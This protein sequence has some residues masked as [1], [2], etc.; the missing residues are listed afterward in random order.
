M[1]RAILTL[2][3]FALVATGFG[4]LSAQ[5]AEQDLTLT[6]CLVQKEAEGDEVA[7]RLEGATDEALSA[8][9][10]HIVAAEGISLG[11]HV[12]HTIEITGAPVAMEAAEA[13]A[14]LAPEPQ[15]DPQ[16]EPP[17]QPELP[18]PPPPAEAQPEAPPAPEEKPEE[19][20]PEA[21]KGADDEEALQI[22]VTELRH[23]AAS[24][25]NMR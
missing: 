15:A 10:I 23:V 16:P 4:P 13:A 3:T 22:R 24:C 21:A 25:G 2:G 12:G 9:E 8:R 14:E 1:R 11:E 20:K 19:K 7:F 18:T 6:G 17:A 5:E